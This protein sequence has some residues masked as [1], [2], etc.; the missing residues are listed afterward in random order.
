MSAPENIHNR[1]ARDY[2]ATWLGTLPLLLLTLEEGDEAAK[3]MV[4][5]ELRRMAQAADCYNILAREGASDKSTNGQ[6]ITK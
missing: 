2:R 5:E 1:Q 6:E 3:A 4:R